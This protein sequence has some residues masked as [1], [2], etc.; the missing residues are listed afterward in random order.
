MRIKISFLSL[1]YTCVLIIT[2][3]DTSNNLKP[4][5]NSYFVKYYGGD[6]NQMA[7]DMIA[8]KDG[9]LVLLGNSNVGDQ[10]IFLVKTDSKGNVIW[11]NNYGGTTDVAKDIEST[12]DGGYVILSDYLASTD[13]MDIKLTQITADGKEVRTSVYGSSYNDNSKA[14]TVLSDGGYI[15]TGY[16]SFDW[17]PSTSIGFE[18]TSSIFHFRCDKDFNFYNE[19]R[20]KN[21][22]GS[23]KNNFGVKVLEAPGSGFYV[24]GCTDVMHDSKINEKINF[25]YYQLDD[26]GKNSNGPTF[27]GSSDK[28]VVM[29][30][31]IEV[32]PGLLSGNLSVGYSTNPV[33]NSQL[34]VLKLK[35]PLQFSVINDRQFDQGILGIRQIEGIAAFPSVTAPQG[36]LILSNEKDETNQ[37]NILLSKINQTG[38][39]VWSASFGGSK[40]DKAASVAEL[41]D[42]KIVILGTVQL[43]IQLKMALL[44]VNAR[45]QFLN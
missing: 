42:G 25:F 33:G 17:E 27:I 38:D 41:P 12:A 5:D 30:A 19:T 23:G 45:G 16:S 4:P 9:T 2:A 36:Y 6:G 44:K 11:Q 32:P 1:F 43:D 24:Y 26:Y 20:W 8:N 7:A 28:D 31:V 34:H 15:I 40:N 3:C 13:N 29:N 35:Y 22:F 21:F 39:A 14:M 18:R 10:H 37:S